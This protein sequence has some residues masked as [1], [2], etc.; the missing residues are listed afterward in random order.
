MYQF[1]S[2]YMDIPTNLSSFH[3]PVNQIGTVQDPVEKRK[4]N[5]KKIMSLVQLGEYQPFIVRR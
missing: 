4:K 2:F 3:Y 1:E 5:L